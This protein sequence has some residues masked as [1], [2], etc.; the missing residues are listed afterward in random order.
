MADLS[1]EAARWAKRLARVIADTPEGVTVL[2]SSGY[3]R[4]LV[5]G[6]NAADGEHMEAERSAATAW[7]RMAPGWRED[8][9]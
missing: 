8:C 3:V 1:P 9:P 5:G 6:E 7:S 2:V 4:V